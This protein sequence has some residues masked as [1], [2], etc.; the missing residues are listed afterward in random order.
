[1]D[2][3]RE[4]RLGLVHIVTRSDAEEWL[5]RHP[6]VEGEFFRMADEVRQMNRQ[7]GAK[8]IAEVIR[9]KAG[10][11][12]FDWWDASDDFKMNNSV[13]SYLARK[14]NEKAR[15]DFFALRKS[16]FDQMVLEV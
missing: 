13:V 8:T 10:I 15:E 4:A 12:L 16:S 2:E 6:G 7:V 1:M 5:R 9:W 14:Y 11:G 3:D